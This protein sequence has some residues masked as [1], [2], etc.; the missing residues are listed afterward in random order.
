[1][2]LN[3]V[4]PL[5]L[6]CAI[7]APLLSQNEGKSLKI[8]GYFQNNLQ[9]TYDT[10]EKQNESSFSLQQ[11]N[12]FFQKDI[13]TNWR[14]FIN[15][16]FLNN[17][18]SRREWGAS[19]LEEAWLRYRRNEKFNLKFGLL[20]PVFNNLNDIKNRTPLLP[21]VIR[22]IVYETSFSEFFNVEQ[23]TPGRAFVQAYGFLPFGNSA[24]LDYALYLGN[25]PNIN[26]DPDKGQTGV[27][28]TSTF[29]IG[30][31]IG[32]RYGDLKIGFSASRD[33]DNQLEQARDVF[34]L[35]GSISRF[36]EVP[37][38]RL[39]ND[40]QFIYDRFSLEG[41]TIFYRLANE[42]EADIERFFYYLTLG[43]QHNEKL[44]TY[45][46]Y[47]YAL[48]KLQLFENDVEKLIF[49]IPTIGIAYY[50]NERIRLK[51]QYASAIS[52]IDVNPI[53]GLPIDQKNNTKY[54]GL[55]ASVFF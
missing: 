49:K 8:F 46:S 6:I 22:Q 20:L 3:K 44:F 23:F 24:K 17:F 32:L 9:H 16:E 18:S 47:W 48:E 4:Y 40:I 37:R 26:N 12:I 45:V 53:D 5:L 41:E 27:D 39:G 38:I 28:T 35:G 2:K 1:M 11:L 15:L 36:L 43:Y 29:L 30:G 31:R 25:S 54:F 42:S 13:T 55:A 10:S 7:N 19:N 52:H 21:Y 34:N 50:L 14:A 33:N 51:A